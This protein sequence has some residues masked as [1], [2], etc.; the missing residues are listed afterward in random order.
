MSRVAIQWNNLLNLIDLEFVSTPPSN[1]IIGNELIQSLS[2]L[3]G[4]TNHDRRFL[5]CNDQGAL[6]VTD[7]WSLLTEVETDEL[8][9]QANT[10]DSFTKSVDN[11]GVLVTTSVAIAKITFVRIS[12]GAAEDIYVP[13]HQWYWF[14]HPVYSITATVVPAAAGTESYVGITAFN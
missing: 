9:P 7:A 3:T 4:A 1:L 6:L 2:W 8:Y 13:A 10:P 14:G 12:G 5:R 11:K